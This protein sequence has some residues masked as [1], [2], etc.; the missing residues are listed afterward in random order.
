MTLEDRVTSLEKQ[1]ET[2]QNRFG[3]FL[4]NGQLSNAPDTKCY[5][6]NTQDYL[7]FDNFEEKENVTGI[8]TA[9]LDCGKKLKEPE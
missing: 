7:S 6:T 8:Y 2:L 1:I 3:Q 5:H 4:I 9:C